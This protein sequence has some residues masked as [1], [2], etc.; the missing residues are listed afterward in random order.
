MPDIPGAGRPWELKLH[1]NNPRRHIFCVTNQPQKTPEKICGPI[2]F[3]RLWSDGGLI[4][5]VATEH[6]DGK[7]DKACSHGAAE[8]LARRYQGVLLRYFA[9]RGFTVSEAQDLSQEVFVQ[10]TRPEVVER[11]TEPE[12]YLFTIAGNLCHDHYRRKAIRQAHPPEDFYENF[13][14]SAEFAPDRLIEGREELDLIIKILR[15]MPERMRNVFVLARLENVP[16]AEIALRL[17]MSK[18]TIEQD[19]ALATAFLA[20]RRRRAT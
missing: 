12:A 4:I 20:A 14:C 13:H 2:G 15:E 8:L 17:G 3:N 6:L 7:Q 11:I 18:R 1:R 19:L 9:R 10:L 16:R 5:I